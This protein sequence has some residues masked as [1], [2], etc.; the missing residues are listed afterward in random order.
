MLNIL[1]FELHDVF[2]LVEEVLVN[3]FTTK[4]P[5]IAVVRDGAISKTN[6]V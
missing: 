5:D 1:R 6:G 3:S 2:A 4:Q